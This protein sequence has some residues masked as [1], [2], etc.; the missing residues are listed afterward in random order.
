[1]KTF[2]L[3]VFLLV[4]GGPVFGQ[5]L[6]PYGGSLDQ[7]CPANPNASSFSIASVARTSNIVTVVLSSTPAGWV[8]NNAVVLSGVPNS[9]DGGSFNS[10]S[11]GVFRLTAVTSSTIQYPQAGNNVSTTSTTGTVTLARFYT[12]KVN[13]RWWLCTPV[14][15]VFWMNG[16]FDIVL[17]TVADYQGIVTQNLAATKYARPLNNYAL[18][19]ATSVLRRMRKWGFNT[20]GEYSVFYPWPTFVNPSWGTPDSTP[21]IH[22]PFMD[23]LSISSGSERNLY[24]VAPAP[25]K[26]MVTGVKL[27]V[28]NMN[29]VYPSFI[30]GVDPFDPNF[31]RWIGAYVSNTS[32]VG[33]DATAPN[34]D[35]FLG[36]V[37]DDSDVMGMTRCGPDFASVSK[38][39]LDTPPGSCGISFG[40]LTLIHSPTETVGVA[41]R[42]GLLASDQLYSDINFYA[43]SELGSWLRGTTDNG[44]G[45][46]S[47]S[48]LNSAW[49]SNY[50]SFGSDA[51]THSNFACATG[52]G[53]TGPYT[54]TLSSAPITPFTVQVFVGGALSGGDD[55][56]GPTA[57]TATS[58]GNIRGAAMNVSSSTINYST[59][60]LSLVFSS[61]VTSGTAITI[62]YQTNGWG[63][64][65]GLLDEDGSCP[66]GS[67]AKPYTVEV[68]DSYGLSAAE[69]LVLSSVQ[70]GIVAS[71]SLNQSAGGWMWTVGTFKAATTPA[72]VNTN[73]NVSTGYATSIATTLSVV[74]GNLLV[75]ACGDQADNT[76]TA[77]DTAGNSFVQVNS[78]DL[79]GVARLTLFY[80]K[81]VTGSASDTITCTYGGSVNYRAIQ[82]LQYSGMNT[83][84]PLDAQT[85]GSSSTPSASFTSAAFSTTAAAEVV[86]AV[87]RNQYGGTTFTANGDM[88]AA[89]CWLPTTVYN[90]SGASPSLAADLDN[91]LYHFAKQYFSV[92]R[93]QIL[94]SYPSLLIFGPTGMGTA[95]A[96]PRKPVLQAAGA[97]LD[98]LGFNT[99]LCQASDDQARYDFVATNGGDKPWINWEGNFANPDSYFSVYSPSGNPV[100]PAVSTQA[101]RGLQYQALTQQMLSTAGTHDGEYHFVG[102]KWWRYYDERAE[103]LNWGLVTPRD[104]PYDGRQ[105]TSNVGSDEWGYESGCQGSDAGP[106]VFPCEQSCPT[107]ST[108]AGAP[109]RYGDFIDYVSAANR[110]WLN[111]VT[112]R[113]R[114]TGKVG[115]KS[116]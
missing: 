81:N 23:V 89:P 31:S 75:A 43:K 74:S 116:Q 105:A 39:T 29:T 53:G 22:M 114:Q 14:A 28:A 70:S 73:S 82:V 45:Y 86:V 102:F 52:N 24:S 9:L 92:A 115:G 1:M 91:F 104:D 27:S 87:G 77:S 66:A 26:G 59:G 33:T 40:Y 2:A 60:A 55:G 6:D 95:C 67:S 90:Y 44:P 15:N 72:L 21:P 18:N 110:Y 84:S 32:L 8:A 3:F 71:M 112:R 58:T 80:A 30:Y 20:I 83:M 62:N 93:T 36:W 19:W 42:D 7:K 68:Q 96:P 65:R 69:D 56:A 79:S 25:A 48:A 99:M 61:P 88:P 78:G 4:A 16:I 100:P 109:V 49:G 76:A 57:A 34:N 64:G 11:N 107:S 103:N 63:V 38:G 85:S 111:Y 94:A 108:C 13:S 98:V 10:P 5:G 35:Y 41:S 50:D 97:E 101:A 51:V 47:I 12:G 46:A 113:Q 106:G 37:T 54:C 17:D